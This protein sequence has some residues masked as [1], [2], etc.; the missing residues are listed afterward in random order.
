MTLSWSLQGWRSGQNSAMA[1]RL[2]AGP[3]V[4]MHSQEQHT[5]GK[6]GFKCRNRFR[7]CR[8]QRRHRKIMLDKTEM[9]TAEIQQ[10]AGKMPGA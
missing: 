7:G 4:V 9:D 1:L 8:L 6:R 10:A 2:S 3:M 5:K